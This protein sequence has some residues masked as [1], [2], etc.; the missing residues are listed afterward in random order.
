MLSLM[1]LPE[2]LK[3]IFVDIKQNDLM[4]VN[5]SCCWDKVKIPSE[6]LCLHDCNEMEFDETHYVIKENGAGKEGKL[7]G[8]LL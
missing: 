3:S 1:K 5:W 2:H 4:L 7:N 6:V 8:L